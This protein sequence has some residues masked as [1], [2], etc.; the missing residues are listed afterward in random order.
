MCIRDRY[1]DVLIPRGGAGLIRSV[2]ENARV[3][4]IETGVG[5]CHVYVDA[6]ADLE[7][8]IR[9]SPGGIKGC[10]PGKRPP[11][12][13]RDKADFPALFPQ[14]HFTKPPFYEDVYKRQMEEYRD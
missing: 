4:V 3:P 11:G 7:M 5:N 1:L 8:C 6:S 12:Q 2:K 10:H 13:G 9:D 14:K